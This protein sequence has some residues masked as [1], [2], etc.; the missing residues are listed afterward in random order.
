MGGHL[1]TAETREG[2]IWMGA[3]SGHSS[4]R[5]S[6]WRYLFSYLRGQGSHALVHCAHSPGPSRGLVPGAW[7]DTLP[8]QRRRAAH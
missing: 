5:A 7:H 2:G 8:G 1:T 3:G 4:K 6:A